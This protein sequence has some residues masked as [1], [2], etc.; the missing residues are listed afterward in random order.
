[1]TELVRSFLSSK[2]GGILTP[3]IVRWP[4]VIGHGGAISLQVGH[5]MD[6]MPSGSW[7]VGATRPG[8]CT[9]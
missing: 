9:I 1:M 7:S 8:S 4:G 3:L 6:V 5:V 2:Q